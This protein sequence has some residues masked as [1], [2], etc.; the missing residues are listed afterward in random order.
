MTLEW[1]AA[2][3]LVINVIINLSGESKYS[4]A[5]AV[6]QASRGALALL[7]LERIGHLG[8]E[9]LLYDGAH[10]LAQP[11][12]ALAQ[13]VLDGSGSRFILGAGHGGAPLGE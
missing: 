12:R 10:D 11:V 3:C 8:F 6:A 13:K 4:V 9:P 1:C 7:G 2:K 5:R